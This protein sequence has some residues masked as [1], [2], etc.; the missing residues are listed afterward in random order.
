MSGAAEKKHG[1]PWMTL[2]KVLL[3]VGAGVIVYFQVE[4]LDAVKKTSG[5]IVTGRLLSG[6]EA[7]SET[8]VIRPVGA[9]SDLTLAKNEFVAKSQKLGLKY[10]LSNLNVGL[11]GLGVAMILFCYVLGIVRWKMLLE[12]Q[13]IHATFFTCFRLTFI[14]F[15]SNNFVPGLTGGDLVKAV[16]VARSNPGRRSAAVGTVIVDRIIGLAMLAFVSSFVVLEDVKTYGKVGSVVFVILIGSIVAFVFCYSKRLRRAIKLADLVKKLPKA[17][18]IKKVDDSLQMYRNHPKAIVWA[19]VLSIGAHVFN[20]GAIA[21]FGMALGIPTD[22]VGVS[23]YF[24]CV[25]LIMILASVPSTPG[26]IGVREALFPNIFK[27]AGVHGTYTGS[28]VTLSFVYT[29]STI[30]LSLI[31]GVFMFAGRKTHEMSA[32]ADEPAVTPGS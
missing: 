21:V 4:W 3:L 6:Q 14:G 20:I 13:G 32:I 28:I 25:P 10:S 29:L 19:M 23:T 30:F 11:W 2:F 12:S 16:I 5:E 15:F 7:D 1:S 26:G 22:H 31:G 17:D 18:I 8:V 9:T 24:A 27:L